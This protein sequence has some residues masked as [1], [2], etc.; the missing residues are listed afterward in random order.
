[1]DKDKKQGII[2]TMLLKAGELEDAE[3][4][5]TQARHSETSARNDREKCAHAYNA[6][7]EAYLKIFPKATV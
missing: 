4:R 2:D 7:L 6:A 1:M 5:A 3:T